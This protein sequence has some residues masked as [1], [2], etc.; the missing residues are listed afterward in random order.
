VVTIGLLVLRIVLG[1]TVAAHGAQKLF[2]VF[3][4]SGLQ[5]FAG[6]LESM[7]V[8]PGRY[9]ALVSA[10]AE[11][12][13]GILVAAGLFT[14]VAALVVAGNLLVAILTV[15]VSKGFWNTK[16][17]YEYPLTLVAGMLAISLVGPG[18]AAVDTLIGLSLPE[19]IT[20]VITAFIVLLG[21]L[22]AVYGRKLP[23]LQARLGAS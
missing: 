22:A 5:K 1:L 19:P 4:G 8:R 3:E 6:M 23:A 9:W 15:H 13:G 2:G 7:G 21:A 16:G 14:P 20:W 12:A 18:R 10:V 17:G 11:F